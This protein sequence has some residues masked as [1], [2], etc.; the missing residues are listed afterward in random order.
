FWR[1]HDA[2]MPEARDPF[3]VAPGTTSGWGMASL[4]GML[5]LIV[6]LTVASAP[7][8]RYTD[9]TAAQLYDPSHYINAV[10]GTPADHAAPPAGGYG[11]APHTPGAQPMPEE[12]PQ[13][14]G[15]PSDVRQQEG[16]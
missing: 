15:A 9:A 12:A 10:L 1:P 11:A 2:T 14:A 6:A 8:I 13:G 3:A 5:A 4:G 16:N 7:V